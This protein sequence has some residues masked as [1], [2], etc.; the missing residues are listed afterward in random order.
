VPN[1]LAAARSKVKRPS[2]SSSDSTRSLDRGIERSGSASRDAGLRLGNLFSLGGSGR[3]A[4][5]RAEYIGAFQ[6]PNGAAMARGLTGM[7]F[8][9][10]TAFSSPTK[11]Q[12]ASGEDTPAT[13]DHVMLNK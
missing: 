7:N 2:A 5:R 8:E 13:S 3:G 1:D 9:E 6:S 10:A 4:A 12:A 11:T